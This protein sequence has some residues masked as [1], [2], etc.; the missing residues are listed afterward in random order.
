MATIVVER[1]FERPMTPDELAA[2][3]ERVNP[4]L[5]MHGAAWIRSYISPDCRRVICEC[6]APDA[7]NVRESYR[8]AGA[9][10]ERVWIA[11]VF[12]HD[13]PTTSY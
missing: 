12:S 4:C 11:Q 2:I 1:T 13:K 7:E 6:E 9:E 3:A 10:F 8:S 5:E